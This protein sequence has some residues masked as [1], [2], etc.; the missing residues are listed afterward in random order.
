[1]VFQKT[2]RK[3]NKKQTFFVGIFFFPF[4]FDHVAD[5]MIN[6]D[7]EYEGLF[8]FTITRFFHK[9]VVLLVVVVCVVVYNIRYFSKSII[10]CSFYN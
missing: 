7:D 2:D 9:C 4:H 10:M 1:M 8:L 3:T 6:C 5:I